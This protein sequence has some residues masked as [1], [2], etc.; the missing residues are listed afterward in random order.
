MGKIVV[1]NQSYKF[2]VF[3]NENNKNTL[4]QNLFNQA[5]QPS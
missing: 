4:G 2:N 3:K 5:T 1:K